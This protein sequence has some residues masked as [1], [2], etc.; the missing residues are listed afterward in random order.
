[1]G[2]R[3]REL[4]E[5]KYG[6]VWV[7]A[8]RRTWAYNKYGNVLSDIKENWTGSLWLNAIRVIYTYN[9][10]RDL[11]TKTT[12]KLGGYQLGICFQNYQYL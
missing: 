1:M 2:N 6:D 7:N 12:E 5:K 3:T 9:N 11:L 8:I 10:N 4:C